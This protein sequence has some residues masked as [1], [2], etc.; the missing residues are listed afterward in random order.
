MRQA[1]CGSFRK[2]KTVKTHMQKAFPNFVKGAKNL[3]ITYTKMY[4]THTKISFHD[5]H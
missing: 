5:N 3:F 1:V 4:K 2:C